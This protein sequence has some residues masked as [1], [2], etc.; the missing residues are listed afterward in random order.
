MARLL[1][2]AL[3]LRLLSRSD[4]PVSRRI[5]GCCAGPLSR[6]PFFAPAP[7]QT[8]DP[9]AGSRAATQAMKEGRFD[10]AARIYRELLRPLPD[11]PGLLMN[12]GMALAMAGHE[13]EAIAPLERAITLKPTLVPA[14]LFLGTS[15]LALG[16][17]GQGRFRP[18]QRVVAAQPANIEYRR[19]L[20]RAYAESGRPLEA[21]DRAAAGSPSSRPRCRRRG[22]RCSTPTTPW[23]RMRW[24]PSQDE[25]RQRPTGRSCC[26]PTRCSPTAASPTRSRSTAR[27]ST[28]LPSMVTHSR[29]DREHLRADGHADWAAIE[30]AKAASP[31]RSAPSARRSVRF[32]PA[33]TARR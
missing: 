22:M 14:Q 33:A 16:A 6:Q 11:D 18:L 32:A 19:L 13:A 20:A 12:L 15:Y 10:D 30:R 26:S 17:A 27:R 8:G 28:A 24:R 21:A 7:P 5:D 3:S 29:L 9:V 1:V 23:R 4:W 25:C 2:D 31:W